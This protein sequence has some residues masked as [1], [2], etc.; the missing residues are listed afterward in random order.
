M[1][2][3][4]LAT[5]L[6][7]CLALFALASCDE[8][9]HADAN[10]DFICD[11][12]GENYDDGYETVLVNFTVNLDADVSLEGK[13]LVLLDGELRYEITLDSAGKADHEVIPGIYQVSLETYLL[14][15]DLVK[16]KPDT[17]S[18][19][20]LAMDNIPDGTA[21]KPFPVSTSNDVTIA[22]NSEVYFI[23]HGNSL[24]YARVYSES[25]A[26]NY[27]GDYYYAVDGLAEATIQPGFSNSD[28]DDGGRTTVF[29]VKN[30]TNETISITLLFE[31]PIG[32]SENPYVLSE[33]TATVTVN[34]DTEI[35]Y[36]WTAD[37]DG[38]LT[39]TT[40]T[41]RNNITLTKVMEGNVPEVFKTEGQLQISFEV[42][43]G[44]EIRIKASAFAPSD[45]GDGQD[46][47]ITFSLNIE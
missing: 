7:L 25:V 28:N 12:C 19:D 29:S 3:K 4:T 32:S 20:I 24:K 44:D 2:I 26:I 13:K 37:K 41:D 14:N 27:D 43:A 45:A 38:V 35:C 31:A 8:C 18:V 34:A 10:D 16:I 30:L 22:P 33:P 17:T 9:E 6:C 47:E 1:K 21:M 39:F 5:L 11:N 36:V 15:V 40:N 23:Y 46:V 42:K